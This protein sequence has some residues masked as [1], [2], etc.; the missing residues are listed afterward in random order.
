MEVRAKLSRLRIAPR[1]VRLVVDVLRG[2]DVEKA[3]H[4]LQFMQKGSALPVLKLLK[5]AV[6]NAVNNFKLDKSN[7]FIKEITVNDGPVLKRWKP[8]AFGRATEVLKRSSH[9]LIVLEE[10]KKTKQASADLKKKDKK[11]PKEDLKIVDAKE[12]RKETQDTKDKDEKGDGKDKRFSGRFKGK[13]SM[14]IHSGDK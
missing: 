8:R 2:M 4:Q 14:L 3:E 6:A 12:L 7:L 13:K 1:K 10:V 9:I 5:S 11:S